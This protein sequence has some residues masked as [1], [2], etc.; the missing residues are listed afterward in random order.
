MSNGMLLIICV[1]IVEQIPSPIAFARC[2][3]IGYGL[4]LEL[5]TWGGDGGPY[6]LDR[7]A[8]PKLS[9]LW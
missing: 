7:S 1:G 4:P 6:I 8:N 5:A 9:L 2:T 3:L